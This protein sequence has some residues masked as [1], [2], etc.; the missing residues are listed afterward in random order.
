VDLLEALLMCDILTL[1]YIAEYIRFIRVDEE[2]RPIIPVFF[3]FI[4]NFLLAIP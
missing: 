4:C 2:R 1:S 3:T